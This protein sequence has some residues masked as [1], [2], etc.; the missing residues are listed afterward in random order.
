MMVSYL[1]FHICEGD[2]RVGMKNYHGTFTEMDNVGYL[3]IL[4]R[5]YLSL[6]FT[7]FI[8]QKGSNEG[9][10]VC[11]TYTEHCPIHEHVESLVS[12]SGTDSHQELLWLTP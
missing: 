8:F 10:I 5:L 1:W 12:D 2:H 7:C 6:D 3:T 9:V 11:A 4:F